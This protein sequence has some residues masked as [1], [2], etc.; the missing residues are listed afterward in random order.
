MQK[1]ILMLSA[2]FITQVLGVN[3][4]EA[5]QFSGPPRKLI[6][7]DAR[8][9]SPAKRHDFLKQG[10]DIAGRD[11]AEQAYELI[12]TAKDL[13]DLSKR[14]VSFSVINDDLEAFAQNLR[15]QDY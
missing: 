8:T 3:A 6:R 9:I 12:A 2:L 5:Q 11:R 7:I 10:F 13:E 15:R 14:G 4:V 1:Q